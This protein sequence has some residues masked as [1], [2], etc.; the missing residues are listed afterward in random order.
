VCGFQL[1]ELMIEQYKYVKQCR[2]PYELVACLSG[3][4]ASKLI[5]HRVSSFGIVVERMIV[6]RWN[7]FASHAMFQFVRTFSN[8]ATLVRETMQSSN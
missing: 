3:E 1:L 4:C 2:Q 7:I 5:S 6:S 8:V